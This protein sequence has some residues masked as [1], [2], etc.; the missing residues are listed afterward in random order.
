[1][2]VCFAF[3]PRASKKTLALRYVR[4]MTS[5]ADELEPKVA[6]GLSWISFE[7]D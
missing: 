6:H 1:M 2:S 3:N 5:F 4:E 7:T